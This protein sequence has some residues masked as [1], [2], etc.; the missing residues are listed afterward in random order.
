MN[1][2]REIAITATVNNRPEEIF[3]KVDNIL[4]IRMQ[5]N[6]AIIH[7]TDGN[8]YQTRMTFF[9]LEE[10]LGDDFIRLSRG[11]LVSAMAI[12]NVTDRINLCNG[13]SLEYALTRKNEIQDKIQERQEAI[14]DSFKKSEL[15]SSAE[16]YNR[17]YRVFDNLPF[18]FTDIEMVF[19]RE[20]R[21]IDW[22]FRYGNKALA[23]LEKLSLETMIGNSF[24]SLFPD[25]SDKWLRN[26]ERAA[27]YGETLRIVDYSPEIDTNLEI[28]CFPTLKGHCG[29]ILFD[30]SKIKF[31]R[32]STDTETAMAIFVDKMLRG[33]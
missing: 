30:V 24:G 29:C 19:D 17:H 20:C 3:L 2:K 4:Y 11:C 23:E 27:L 12:H 28:I 26:Y 32:E 25:M 22:I 16:E 5:R 8:V 10:L 6:Y 21:A 1:G 33:N 31:Y 15:P 9:E 13:E 7:V 18:A 14:I